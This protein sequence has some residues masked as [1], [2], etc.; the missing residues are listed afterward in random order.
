[1]LAL[2]LNHIATVQ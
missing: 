2:T 1:M